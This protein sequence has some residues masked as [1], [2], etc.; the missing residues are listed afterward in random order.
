MYKPEGIISNNWRRPQNIY[1]ILFILF[2]YA[3]LWGMWTVIDITIN[4]HNNME[5]MLGDFTWINIDI[6][7]CFYNLNVDICMKLPT[8]TVTAPIITLNMN[9]RLQTGKLHQGNN[10]GKK[11]LNH[12]LCALVT[13]SYVFIKTQKH[14]IYPLPMNVPTDTG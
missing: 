8:Y 12:V 11:Q 10:T 6:W 2:S 1:F 7:P 4:L 14:H 3:R 5:N 13:Y 9:F